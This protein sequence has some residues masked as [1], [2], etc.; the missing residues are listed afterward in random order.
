MSWT[1]KVRFLH[2]LRSP[3][4]ALRVAVM[5]VELGRL[6]LVFHRPLSA[7]IM[8]QERVLDA[9]LRS[10]G[11]HFPQPLSDASAQNLYFLIGIFICLLQAGRIWLAING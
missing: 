5:A 1:Q 7:R 11:I 10:R 2:R 9:Y 3:A 4:G 8:E 6:L